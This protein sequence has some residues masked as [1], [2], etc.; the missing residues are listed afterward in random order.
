HASEKVGEA[1]DAAG[2]SVSI[3]DYGLETSVAARAGSGPLHIVIC[4]EYDALPGVGHACGHNIIAASAVGAGVALASVADDV[5]LT[6][7]VL[8][9]PAEEGGGGKILMMERGAFDGV[10]A[11]MMVHPWPQD[12]LTGACLAVDHLEIDY[13]GRSAHASAAPWQ[14]INAG[15]ALVV[16]QVAVGLLRQQLAPGNQVHGIVRVGGDATNIIPSH[17]KATYMLRAR[18]LEQL[19]SLRPRVHN[20]FEA[21]AIATGSSWSMKELSPTYSHMET[22]PSLLASWR[23]NAESLGRSYAA[24]D[25]GAAMPTLST[26]MANISLAIPTI[27]PLVGIETHGAVNHQ[28]EFTAACVGPSAVRATLD[29]A[30]GMAW[31]AIDAATDEAIREPL[32]AR[33]G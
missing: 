7:T 2:F 24:D 1:L 12:W 6:V 9:T 14:G 19:E 21:G 13:A 11:A 22:N 30:I 3:G 8:G 33:I 27:H 15:D 32:L 17:S 18:T 26:D 4:A 5:G 25:S 10:H 23:R 28:P 29:G 31:T 16:A 20:C